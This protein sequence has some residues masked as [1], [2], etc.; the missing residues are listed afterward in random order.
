MSLYAPK[1][2]EVTDQ[3]ELFSFVRQHGFG[4]LISH[5]QG[6]LFVSHIPFLISDDNRRL[7][8]HLARQNPQQEDIEGQ[9]ILVVMNGPHGYISPTW[10]A[11]SGVPTWNFQAV[12]IAG[13]A[14]VIND[15]EW[16]KNVI[17]GLSEKYEST[18]PEPWTMNYPEQMLNHIVGIEVEILE[19]K[20]K[21]KLSQNRSAADRAGV[22]E[23]LNALGQKELAGVME[24]YNS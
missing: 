18:S 14:K 23:K 21:Y 4:Q 5:H 3:H 24:K 6:E 17:H 11:D 20:G 16:V 2:F 1:S 13:K 19:I 8:C 22:I 15:P 9:K 10:Y 7:L 12:H